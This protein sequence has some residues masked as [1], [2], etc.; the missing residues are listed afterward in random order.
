MIER[1]SSSPSPTNDSRPSRFRIVVVV[2]VVAATAGS[3]LLAMRGHGDK[4]TTRDITA[5]L[6][7][8]GHPGVLAAGSG[9]LWV[10]LHGEPRGRVG[11]QPLAHL[12]LATGTVTQTVHVGGEA[13]ALTGTTSL[14]RI[15]A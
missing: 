9:G 3:L 12:D 10:A 1:V 7:V 11:D 2:S 6:A 15:L 5:T 4:T 8:P 13:S 14:Q